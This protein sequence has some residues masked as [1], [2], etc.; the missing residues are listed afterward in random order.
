MWAV[1]GVWQVEPEYVE[2]MRAQVPAM[3]AGKVEMEGFVFGTWTVDGHTLFLF[4]DEASARRYYDEM[5]RI[6]AVHGPGTRCVVYDVAE[7]AAQARG[8]NAPDEYKMLPTVSL[9][10]T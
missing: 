7:V 2:A 4:A 3:A 10:N 8:A 6:D 9:R 1:I 5:L